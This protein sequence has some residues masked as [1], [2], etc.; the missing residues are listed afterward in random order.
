MFA[1]VLP[2]F[3]EVDL[4]GQKVCVNFV[5]DQV[6]ERHQELYSFFQWIFYLETQ[7]NNFTQS[8]FY[9]CDLADL[10]ASWFPHT[11]LDQFVRNELLFGPPDLLVIVLLLLLL[12]LQQLFLLC[13]LLFFLQLSLLLGSS[14]FVPQLLQLFVRE[15]SWRRQARNLQY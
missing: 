3:P 5:F 6:F 2:T 15:V 10:L 8:S 1:C 13:I 4:K 14:L 12:V 11:N 9:F 7:R